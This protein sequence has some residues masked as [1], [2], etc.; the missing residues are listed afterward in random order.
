MFRECAS[1]GLIKPLNA[2]IQQEPP[3]TVKAYKF[4]ADC[5]LFIQLEQRKLK[6]LNR[7]AVIKHNW[8]HQQ[9]NPIT[10]KLCNTSRPTRLYSTHEKDGSRFH[11]IC[12]HCERRECTRCEEIKPLVEFQ[13]NPRVKT[14]FH[15][16]CKACKGSRQQYYER[17][18]GCGS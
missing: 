4:C 10:C 3:K 6:Y 18:V 5:N 13:R 14:C 17:N 7:E 9:E 8:E 12:A 11:D 2:Y 15:R 16:S 1:C